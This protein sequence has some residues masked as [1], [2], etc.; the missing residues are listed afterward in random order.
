MEIG[1]IF[2]KQKDGGFSNEPVKVNNVGYYKGVDH[3]IHIN[4]ESYDDYLIIYNLSGNTEVWFNYNCY[5][6]SSG[7]ITVIPPKTYH[8]F[9]YLKR[10]NSK[11]YWCH[12]SGKT[13]TELIEKIISLHGKTFHIGSY[14]NVAQIFMEMYESMLNKSED[15]TN[16][17]IC[18]LLF[19]INA[20]ADNPLDEEQNQN[21]ADIL[22]AVI[23]IQNNYNKEISIE[24]LSEICHLS[25][26]NF[27]RKFKNVTGSPVHKFIADYR[28]MQAKRL[29]TT[30]EFNVKEIAAYVGFSDNMY[31]SRAFKKHCGLSPTEYKD[32]TII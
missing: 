20:L 31:F 24:E 21:V 2:H 32:K 25:K 18:T 12:F 17:L 7:S 4:N 6:T 14:F 11:Y 1:Q 26:Y 19:S 28:M 13:A 5:K 30:T 3:N 9:S 22:K 23:Y 16:N 29:L 27:M 10:E 8:K 15:I